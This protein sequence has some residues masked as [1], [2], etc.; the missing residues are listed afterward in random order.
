M[1]VRPGAVMRLIPN[2]REAWKFHTVILAALLGAVNFA[3]DHADDLGQVGDALATVLPP[4]VMGAL[5]RWVPLAL[6]VLRLVKQS[7]T[8]PAA[9][10]PAAPAT[11]TESQ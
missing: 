9:T 7:N 11:P 6:I 4:D 2:W 10:A 3:V 8:A 5:N 1:A